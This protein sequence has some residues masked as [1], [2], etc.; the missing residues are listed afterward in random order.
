MYLL[1]VI[2][3]AAKNFNI[4]SQNIQYYLVTIVLQHCTFKI[5]S[6]AEHPYGL[7]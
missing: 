2:L 7:W 6:A 4:A 3:L 5:S 1:Q